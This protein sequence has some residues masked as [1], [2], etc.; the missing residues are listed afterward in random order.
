MSNKLKI[1]A[2]VV[3]MGGFTVSAAAAGPVAAHGVPG[4]MPTSISGPIVGA[5]SVPVSKSNPKVT[6]AFLGPEQFTGRWVKDKADFD[7]EMHSLDPNAT[8]LDYN[9][10]ADIT[11]QTQNADSAETAGAKVIILAAVD[12]FEDVPIVTHARSLGIDVLAYDRMIQTSQLQAYDSF[13]NMGVGVLQ[14]TW[15]KANVPKGKIVEILGSAT[16]HNEALF[17]AGFQ[18]VVGPLTKKGGK[19][20]VC[21]SSTTPNWDPPTAGNE[22]KS[23]LTDCGT[24]IKGVYSMNDGMAADVYTQLKDAG[25]MHLPL[26]GQDAQPD[27]LGRI[28]LHEQ[29][30]TVFKNVKFEADAAAVAAE[31]WVTHKALPKEYLR[32]KKGGQDCEQINAQLKYDG[33]FVTCALFTPDAITLKN[34]AD[35]VKAGFD[36]WGTTAAG[37][38]VCPSVGINNSKPYCGLKH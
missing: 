8:I 24:K 4:S 1:A 13:D 3:L 27:G 12:Q 29:G 14:G 38:G 23:A 32:G 9:A 36:T 37:I 16:D 30:M 25:L 31:A 10:N 20:D 5:N 33:H 34:V 35:P 15:F 18:K 28:L 26:T 2:S 17:N 22:M 19:Y 11:T 21:Y 7:K 6:V